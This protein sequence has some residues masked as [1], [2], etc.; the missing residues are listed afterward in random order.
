[1]RHL[2]EPQEV[3]HE[4]AAVR[5]VHLHDGDLVLGRDQQTVLMVE[6][7]SQVDAPADGKME[8]SAFNMLLT[9]KSNFESLNK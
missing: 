1:M 8:A 7:S 3:L 5:V 2:S 6:D 4:R 9:M